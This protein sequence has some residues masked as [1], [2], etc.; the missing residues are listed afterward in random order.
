MGK[1]KQKNEY[2]PLRML[3]SLG[4][5][6]PDDYG[7]GM[8]LDWLKHCGQ[9]ESAFCT[10]L[11]ERMGDEDF[12]RYLANKQEFLNPDASAGGQILNAWMLEMSGDIL[13]ED[14]KNRIMHRQAALDAEMKDILLLPGVWTRWSQSKQVYKPDADFA[15][16]LLET[17]ELELT[18]DQLEHLPADTFYVDLSACRDF[19]PI[20]GGMVSVDRFPGWAGITVYLLTND[21]AYFSM[22]S[23]GAYKDHGIL[24]WDIPNLTNPTPNEY[25]VHDPDG[26]TVHYE[27][28]QVGRTRVSML[29]MQILCYLTSKRPD[30][31]E[32]PLTASTYRPGQKNPEKPRW[33]DVEI[34]DV[35][36]RYGNTIRA[37]KQEE[38]NPGREEGS[39]GHTGRKPPRPH[40]RRAHWQRYWTGKGRTVCEVV[41]CAP[42]FIGRA[43]EQADVTVHRIV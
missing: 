42:S 5:L 16:A 4:R 31:R 13:T 24:S 26:R 40:F 14:V 30:I 18:R 38:K 22:Y 12:N 1:K 37:M 6:S 9:K 36:V 21:L 33:S 25:D 34:H 41:W 2:P 11:L 17:E 29:C 32:S 27:M 19:Q 35:G 15:E 20:V 10:E 43:M 7:R 23:G 8:V 28:P 3:K 39:S